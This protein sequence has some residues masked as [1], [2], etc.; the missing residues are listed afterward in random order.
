M[1]IARTSRLAL[2]GSSPTA[3]CA[4]FSAVTRVLMAHLLGDRRCTRRRWTPA[5]E[6][7][8]QHDQLPD[9]QFL[10]PRA[11][12][13]HPLIVPYSWCAVLTTQ[14]NLRLLR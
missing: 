10:K 9:S 12:P 4:C 7:E 6:T 8:G 13:V 5:E 11:E 1:S 2:A 3:M 14:V